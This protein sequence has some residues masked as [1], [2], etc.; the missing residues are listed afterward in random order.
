MTPLST[1]VLQEIDVSLADV[2]HVPLL[3]MGR[4]ILTTLSIL[5]I[6]TWISTIHTFPLRKLLIDMLKILLTHSLTSIS[7]TYVYSTL[8]MIYLTTMIPLTIV[9]IL[10][11]NT[12][13]MHDRL[14]LAPFVTSSSDTKEHT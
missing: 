1:H 2:P 7:N 14:G 10:T 5:T 13:T 12:P 11:M 3:T 8:M 6:V 4:T 9:N